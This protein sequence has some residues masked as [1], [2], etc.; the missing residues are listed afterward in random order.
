MGATLNIKI[1]SI[2]LLQLSWLLF[3]QFLY[4]LPNNSELFCVH[5]LGPFDIMAGHLV[6]TNEDGSESILL[7]NDK[8]CPPDPLTFPA[9]TKAGPNSKSLI[10]NFRAFKFPRSLI[11]RFSVMVQFCPGMCPPVSRDTFLTFFTLKEHL[12]SEL[13]KCSSQVSL[14]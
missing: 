4:W 9:F 3:L 12:K 14:V 11:V 6:A 8:G 13:Q 7:L 1:I 2:S 10:A 5:V